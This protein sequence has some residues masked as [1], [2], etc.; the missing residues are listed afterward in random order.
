[1]IKYISMPRLDRPHFPNQY[2]HVFN[3]GFDRKELFKSEPDYIRFLSKLEESVNKFDWLIYSYCLLPN[4]FHIQTQVKEDSLGVILHWLQTSH[5][6]YFNKKYKHSGAVFTNR[7]KSI[8]I[9]KEVY[10]LGLSKYIHLNPVQARLSPTPQD[11]PYSSYP[12]IIN[13]P[14]HQY[15]IID[16]RSI[17]SLTGQASLTQYRQFVEESSILNYDPSVSVRGIAG[18][19]RFR[20]QFE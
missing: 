3:R 15:K 12:E 14:K 6:V 13:E 4:H 16:K 1:M 20:F 18:S 8:L 19:D 10:H 7:F 9:Q 17:E 5:S 11:Y 2:Y